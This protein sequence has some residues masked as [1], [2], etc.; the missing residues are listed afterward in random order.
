MVQQIEYQRPGHDQPVH[1]VPRQRQPVVL[2]YHSVAPYSDDPYQVTVSPQRFEQQLRWLNR[3][4][5]RGVS[6]A[7]LNAAR[8]RNC[9]DGL[10]GLTFDDGY[11]DFVRYVMPALQRYGFTATAFVIAGRL[12]GVNAWDVKGPRKPLMTAGQVREVAGAGLEIGSH[13]LRHVTLERTTGLALLR[14]QRLS[15]EILQDV[16]GIGIRG[17]CYPY[18]HLDARVVD[19]VQEAGYDYGCAIWP[20]ELTGPYALPRV[21][22]G[23][24]DGPAR[25]RAK[26]LRHRLTSGFASQAGTAEPALRRTA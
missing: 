8:Q 21:Y 4:G 3:R 20:S 12:G 1:Q 17:F 7:E 15:R 18:G 22:V 6:M 5:L 9:D 19:G 25:L 14:E 23:Q 24:S 26:W 16:T 11:E 10:V 13:G 2:M